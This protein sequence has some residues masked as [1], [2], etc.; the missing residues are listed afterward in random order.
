MFFGSI[1]DKIRWL[2][3]KKGLTQKALGLALGFPE[4]SADVRIRHFES[5]RTLPDSTEKVALAMALEVDSSCFS[6]FEIN[7]DEDVI[8]ALFE[9][10]DFKPD[11]MDMQLIN[12]ELHIVFKNDKGYL[13]SLLHEWYQYRNN[14]NITLSNMSQTFYDETHTLSGNHLSSDDIAFLSSNISPVYTDFYIVGGDRSFFNTDVSVAQ[15][16]EYMLWESGIDR[17]LELNR[18]DKMQLIEEYYSPA[19]YSLNTA[20]NQTEYSFLLQILCKIID[21]TEAVKP[22]IYY[23]EK[24]KENSVFLISIPYCFLMKANNELD[25]SLAQLIKSAN[26]LYNN[27]SKQFAPLV[28]STFLPYG[29]ALDIYLNSKDSIQLYFAVCDYRK[30]KYQK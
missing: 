19:N 11:T 30:N 5:G 23:F 22:G 3:L 1:G 17:G 10:A 29:E 18:N 8:H 9:I 27:G 2:R 21:E 13:F 26:M 6:S 12:D 4:A 24:A 25:A 16:E 20:N 15:S 28:F 14:H 7:S